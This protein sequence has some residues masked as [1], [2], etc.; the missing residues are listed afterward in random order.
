MLEVTEHIAIERPVT[1]VEAQFGDVAHHE[2]SGVHRGVQFVVVDE[3]AE[4]CVYE[5][6]TRLGPAKLRQSFRL[7]RDDPARQVNVI[8]AGAFRGGSITFDI[9]PDRE[10]DVTLVSATLRAPVRGITAWL[11]PVLRRALSRSLS[12]ALAEDRRD[13]ESGSYLA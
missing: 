9:A 4:Y 3:T 2:R 12:K 11:A 10:A 13:L 7:E 1:V 6:I 5:Q 8:I